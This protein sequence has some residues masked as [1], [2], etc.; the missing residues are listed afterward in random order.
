MRPTV[1]VRCDSHAA[2]APGV[3]PVTWAD[4][5]ALPSLDQYGELSHVSHGKL[6]R[7]ASAADAAAAS[8]MA[9]LT[10]VILPPSV[11]SAP[12]YGVVPS[13]SAT[14]TFSAAKARA[15]ATARGKELPPMPANI[16]G[17]SVQ[18]TTGTAVV[19]NYGGD[20]DLLSQAN[21]ERPKARGTA[22]SMTAKDESGNTMRMVEIADAIPQLIAAQAYAPVATSSGASPRDLE[23]YLL[24]Q[25]GISDNLA[26]AIRAIGDPATAWPIPV[27][28]GDVNTHAVSV[29]GVRGTVF[30]DT[31]GFATG[32]I[33][34]KGGVIHAIAGPLSESDVLGVANSLR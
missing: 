2:D 26:N 34:M 8:G 18:I 15:A 32:V 12:S 24:S 3:V 28:V 16:D 22:R 4:L 13:L 5:R 33:W 7:V 25:P 30:S 21:A 19:A 29:Q 6:Q 10:P 17:S 11:T 9:V 14:F 20:L 1:R 27:P 31:G 23:R